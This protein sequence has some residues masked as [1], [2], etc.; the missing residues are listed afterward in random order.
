MVFEEEKHEEI[1]TSHFNKCGI[2]FLIDDQNEVVYVGQSTN[3]YDRCITHYKNK[4]ILF[5]KIKY[6]LVSESKLDNV[7]GYFI[8]KYK[9]KYNIS[10]TG[11]VLFKDVRSALQRDLG[12]KV[13]Q[14]MIRDVMRETNIQIS[15]V[16]TDIYVNKEDIRKAVIELKVL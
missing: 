5:T 16:G 11:Y 10:L 6:L 14:S 3:I 1:D 12:R 13:K 8:L 7:E 9:P 4:D 2:Y 15:M